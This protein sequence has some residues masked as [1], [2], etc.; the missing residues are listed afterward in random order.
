MEFT[1]PYTSGSQPWKGTI[2]ILKPMPT[3]IIIIAIMVKGKFAAVA[4]CAMVVKL[5]VVPV[6][7]IRR[8][9]PN[10]RKTEAV[11]PI[12][13]YLLAPS[14]DASSFFMATRA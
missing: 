8:K 13:A 5:V 2:P 9:T 4:T 12:S 7:P 11:T 3:T 1:P 10:I 14:S 6:N